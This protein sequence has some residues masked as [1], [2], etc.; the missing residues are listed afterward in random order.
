MSVPD[1]PFLVGVDAKA[2]AAIRERMIPV[3]L[4]GGRTL[5]EE[6]ELGDALYTLVTGSIGIS[7]RD[8][9]TGALRRIA[10]LRPPDTVGEMAL[11]SPA[12]RSATAT[13]LRDTHLLRLTRQAFKEVI[14]R[15]PRML[16]YFAGLLAERLRRAFE[17]RPLSHAPRSFAVLGVTMGQ[18]V[19]AFGRRLAQAFDE[20]LPGTTG[21]LTEWPEGADE[22][23]F[24]TFEMAHARTIFVAHQ[25][26]C[27]WCRLSLHHADHVLL[28]ADPGEALLPGAAAHLA[29]VPSEWIRMDLVIRQE[30]GAALPCQVHPTV[31][32]LPVSMRIQVREGDSRDHCRL[33]RLASGSAHGLVLGGG[34]ARGLAHLGVL[35]ALDEAGFPI[36]L[37]GGT[38]M[39]AIIAA[40]LATGSPLDQIHAWAVE[41]FAGRNP[42]NDYTLPYVALARGTKVDAGLSRSFGDVRIEDL[43]LPFF[44]VSSNLT[45]GQVMV[46]S[47]GSLV[48]A[49]RASI[50]IPGLLPP[51]CTDA[52][53]LVDGGMMNNLPAN[54]MADLERG[55]VLAA[56]V[57]SDLAFDG[58]QKRSWRG[59]LMRQWLGVPEA[60]PAIVPLLLRAATVSGDAQTMMAASRATVVLKPPLAG[61]D[62]RAWS[63]LETASE[64]GYRH[65][66]EAIA[67]GRL[68]EWCS[69]QGQSPDLPLAKVRLGNN[70]V[71]P[72]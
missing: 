31:A 63:S 8:P 9:R 21:C 28:L 45:T 46:H 51:V 61:I 50:A 32:A 20:I 33:A 67:E 5:F 72:V 13:A 38:S 26:D 2:A 65:T 12:P 71:L 29:R 52:G 57:G 54:V 18:P 60:M 62:L 16:L 15:H 53:I 35:R 59:H 58:V 30:A 19:A 55:T 23:W 41:N 6:G 25:L 70:V 1:I 49:L 14:E 56:D 64:L 37:V 27:P 44:C 17:G 47:N 10:R 69:P 66:C 7:T 40:S 48:E 36:D 68:R 22:V 42:L 4:P 43:W 34:G 11:L 39:G 3:A 24:H